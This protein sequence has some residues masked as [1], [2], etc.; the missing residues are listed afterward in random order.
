MSGKLSWTGRLAVFSF[1]HKWMM[2]GAWL[3]LLIAAAGASAG[4]SSVLTTEFQD[5]S[6]SESRRAKDAIDTQLGRQPLT[7]TI[8]VRSDRYTVSDPEFIQH[9]T[10][11]ITQVAGVPGVGQVLTFQMTADPGMISNDRHAAIASAAM[12]A[13]PKQAE[14]DVRGVVEAVRAA[15]TDDFRVWT[16]GDASAN[17]ELNT[18]SE[19]DIQ[20]AEQIGLPV[21]LAVMVFAFGTVVSAFVPLLLGMAAIVPALGATALIGRGFELSFFVTNIITMIGLAVGIDYSMFILGRYREEL[22]HGRPRIQAAG[23]A[24]DTSGRAV[25][26]SGITVLLALTGMLFV[27]SNIFISIGIG[28]ITVVVFAIL[29]SLTLLPAL[30][31]IIG[32]GI[33]WLRIPVVGKAHAGNRFWGAVTH[34]VQARPVL[35]VAGS[36]GLLLAAALPLTTID[37]GSNGSETLPKQTETYQAIRA[38]QQDFAAGRSDPIRAVVEGPIGAPE[39]QVAIARFRSGIEARGLQWL[40]LVP[41][42][43][44]RTAM[45]LI[46]SPLIGTGDE[47]QGVIATLRDAVVPEAFGGTN[48]TVLVGGN[49]ASYVDVQSEMDSKVVVVFSF[50]LGLSF[51][52]LLLVFRSIAIPV[53][54]IVMNLLSVGAAYGLIVLVFQHG[55]LADQLGFTKTPQVEFWLPLFLF[56]IL[57]GLSM[58]YHVFLLSRVKEEWTRTG[59]NK[60]AVSHGVTST[61]GMITSAA[62]I[63]VAVFAAFSR[64]QLVSLQQMGFGLA[65][66]VFLDATIVRSV[67]VP[68]SMQLLGRFNWWFPSWLSWLP[69]L[70]VEGT[71]AAAAGAP[72]PAA[73]SVAAG[74]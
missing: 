2:L 26:F 44:G 1:Q 34:A 6:G 31:G 42:D 56:S 30:I 71:P 3:L 61:A 46:A 19:H 18:I 11:L 51:V 73:I 43:D 49:L 28:A 53:K 55:I 4:L 10:S 72:L 62:V 74:D 69:A 21:A 37:L 20:A 24:A 12:T 65:V 50:V 47:A 68:A 22:A 14:K 29:A 66:A 57:F 15:R 7:E 25:F 5:L 52:L 38:L 39:V 33:G 54:A 59:N 36:A 60:L 48:A 9:Y 35:F 41:S 67:L 64:G 63:M 40:D 13:E 32:R 45:L 58:D 17:R 27:R 16:I 8:I 23:I 70:N